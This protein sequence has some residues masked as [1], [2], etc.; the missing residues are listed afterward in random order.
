MSRETEQKQVEPSAVSQETASNPAET[1]ASAPAETPEYAPG[2][3]EARLLALDAASSKKALHDSRALKRL[4]ILYYVLAVFFVFFE[5]ALFAVPHLPG[6]PPTMRTAI[7]ILTWLLL[8]LIVI[9][10]AFG[11]ALRTQRSTA[12]Q[13]LFRIVAIIG[14]VSG[15]LEMIAMVRQANIG[16]FIGELVSLLISIRLCVITYN[17][18]LFGKNAP[19]HNQLGY[20]RSKWKAGEKP[21]HIPEH[22]HKQ[23]GYAKPCFYI[24]FLILPYSVWHFAMGLSAQLEYSKAQEY[25]EAGQTLFAEAG[26]AKDPHAAMAKYAEAYFN[27]RRAASDP[28]NEDVHVY[29]G[30]CAARGLGCAQDYFEAFRQLTMHPS[31]TVF[32]PDAEY[33]LGLLYLYGHGVTQD[34]AQAAKYLKDA[35][36]KGQRD[37]KA[38]LGYDMSDLDADGNEV[39]GA[40]TSYS[41]PDYGGLT[42]EQYLEKKIND[43]AVRSA[44]KD[45]PEEAESAE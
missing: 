15:V 7:V 10:P 43:K 42:V 28:K 35:A 3:V 14:I 13:W 17:R 36:A 37:A 45:D 9:I 38:L 20:V 8:P 4:G 6:C 22:K 31:A 21:E 23:P 5:L 33:E 39:E 19:S 34:I 11:V 29:L 26:Q 32:F 1:P 18:V 16:G 40:E 44:G 12:A 27:F 25:Y 41:E 30:L 24:A 2:S